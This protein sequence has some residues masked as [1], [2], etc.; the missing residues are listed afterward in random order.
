MEGNF[1]PL[2]K[3]RFGWKVWLN[4]K[5]FFLH[6]IARYLG[7]SALH[8]CKV[9]ELN[10]DSLLCM[11]F[12]IFGHA[13]NKK[14]KVCKLYPYPHK[15]QLKG[16]LCLGCIANL[17]VAKYTPITLWFFFLMF[18]FSLVG[19]VTNLWKKGEIL[20]KIKFVCF[21][22]YQM[23]VNISLGINFHSDIT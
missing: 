19:L 8:L 4:F 11:I 22:C 23:T 13:E 2:R 7:C 1:D 5:L 10:L 17:S 16:A 9:K 20:A 12:V 3:T 15:A 21:H 6:A 14:I 18:S